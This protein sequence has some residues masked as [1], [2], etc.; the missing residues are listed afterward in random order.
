MKFDSAGSASFP[1]ESLLGLVLQ[2]HQSV[3]ASNF[4]KIVTMN[5]A[6]FEHS[7]SKIYE[8]EV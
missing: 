8:I 1:S 6:I 3:G 5:S 2:S 4:G 7:F